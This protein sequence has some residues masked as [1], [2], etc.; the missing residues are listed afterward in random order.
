MAVSEIKHYALHTIQFYYQ[1]YQYK[2][3]LL[4]EQNVR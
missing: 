1:Y 3:V 2:L 4:Y